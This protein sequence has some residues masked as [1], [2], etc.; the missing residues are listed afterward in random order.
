[1][2]GTTREK[3]IWIGKDDTRICLCDDVDW[4]LALDLVGWWTVVDMELNLQ[5]P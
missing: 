5:V 2:E 1:M 4:N 3:W